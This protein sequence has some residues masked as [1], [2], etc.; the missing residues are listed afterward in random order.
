MVDEPDQVTIWVWLS[1]ADPHKPRGQQFLGAAIVEASGRDGR[2]IMRSAMDRAWK[3]GINPGGSVMPQ[4]VDPKSFPEDCLN[5][6]LSRNEIIER[7]IGEK[8]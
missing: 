2:E 7:D 3:L 5:R 4:Q 6:L 1:F 8:I